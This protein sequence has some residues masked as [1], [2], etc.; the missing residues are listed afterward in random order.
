MLFSDREGA[1]ASWEMP[2]QTAAACPNPEMRD[3]WL[4]PP[5]PRHALGCSWAI[6][7]HASTSADPLCSQFAPVR[8]QLCADS[9]VL[10]LH[11]VHGSQNCIIA[12]HSRTAWRRGGDLLSETLPVCAALHCTHCTAR[13]RTALA[14][15]PVHLRPSMFHSSCLASARPCAAAARFGLRTASPFAITAFWTDMSTWPSRVR[16]TPAVPC[17]HSSEFWWARSVPAARMPPSQP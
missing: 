1:A 9:L 12:I 5:W 6:L 8:V 7:S 15:S 13:H 10:S 3:T 4:P 16:L 14:V 11:P 2:Y 17:N